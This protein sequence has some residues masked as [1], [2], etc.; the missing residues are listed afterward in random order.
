MKHYS[1]DSWQIE[2]INRCWRENEKKRKA[3]KLIDYRLKCVIRTHKRRSLELNALGSY[4]QEQWDQLRFDYGYTC[5]CCKKSEPQIKLTV[6]HIVPLTKSGTNSIENIQ[7]LCKSCNSS[8]GVRIIRY[9][10]V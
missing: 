2:A 7:P 6:D 8:K 4:T 9:E 3:K 1:P 10:R 5:P